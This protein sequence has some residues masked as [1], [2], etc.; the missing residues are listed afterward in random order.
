MAKDV[1]KKED[2]LPAELSP[3]EQALVDAM[4]GNQTENADADSFAIPFLR[5]LQS[6]SPQ[7]EA[8]EAAYI[9]D[10]RPGMIFNTVTTGLYKNG[11][12]IIQAE[13][14]REFIEWRPN[15]G[16]FVERH[17][18]TSREALNVR[19]V[20]VDGRK[21]YLHPDN[22]NMLTDTRQHYVLFREVNGD[23]K[24]HPALLPMSSTQLKKSR[25]L[26]A[27]IHEDAEARQL[28]IY[29]LGSGGESNDA[30]N[31]YGWTVTPGPVVTDPQVLVAVA[32]FKKSIGAGE[33]ETD[34]NQMQDKQPEDDDIPF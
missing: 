29:V 19:T 24:W 14:I 12:E 15:R 9:E 32:K 5:I 3:E 13:F 21:R 28:R 7:C 1:A 20:E 23:G 18:P 26:M 16:G 34:M 25:K 33:V 11:I 10:A 6:N 31:W 22:E 4:L 30:G 17:A 2:A 27:N 8:Q